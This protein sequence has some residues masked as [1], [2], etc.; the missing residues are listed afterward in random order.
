MMLL[1]TFVLLFVL[2]LGDAESVRKVLVTEHLPEF[3]A[4][5]EQFELAHIDSVFYSM[6]IFETQYVMRLNEVD[7]NI[8]VRLYSFKGASSAVSPFYR[9]VES[10]KLKFVSC[11]RERSTACLRRMLRRSRSLF[12]SSRRKKRSCP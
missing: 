3:E 12:P 1:L 8:M 10:L 5:L 11:N 6:N 9:L 7:F 2:S 4:F